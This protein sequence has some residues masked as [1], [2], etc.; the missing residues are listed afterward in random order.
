MGNLGLWFNL[1]FFLIIFVFLGEVQA[2]DHKEIKSGDDYETVKNFIDSKGNKL[3]A[4]DEN[5]LTTEYGANILATF[6][7]KDN[8][9]C[10]VYTNYGEREFKW[11]LSDIDYKIRQHGSPFKVVSS[12]EA[13][14][15][16]FTIH[17]Q[18][19]N[20]TLIYDVGKLDL[21]G[22]KCSIVKSTEIDGNICN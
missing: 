13:W 10:K 2:F 6:V 12:G 17:W 20:Q 21:F 14:G 8:K 19:Q 4:L 5:R 15:D 9:L 1:V 18:N 16:G 11:I 7:F 3:I 22:K